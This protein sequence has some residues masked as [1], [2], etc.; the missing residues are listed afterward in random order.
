MTVTVFSTKNP[1]NFYDN[2][3]NS[4]WTDEDFVICWDPDEEILPNNDD[5]NFRDLVST[6]ISGAKD[7][8]KSAN[9][10]AQDANNECK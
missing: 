9:K 1:C 7:A 10:M 8:N 2:Q 4:T 3:R 6:Q 5:D